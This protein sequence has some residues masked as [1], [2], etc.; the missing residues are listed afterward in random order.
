MTENSSVITGVNTQSYKSHVHV[1]TFEMGLFNASVRSVSSIVHAGPRKT[2]KGPLWCDGGTNSKDKNLKM[3]CGNCCC[4]LAHIKSDSTEMKTVAAPSF[5]RRTSQQAVV[6]LS[7]GVAVLAG[8]DAHGLFVRLPGL[9]AD[10]QQLAVDLTLRHSGAVA[11]VHLQLEELERTDVRPVSREDKKVF[12]PAGDS[13]FSISHIRTQTV[14]F[15][16]SSQAAEGVWI[17][18]Q[19]HLW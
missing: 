18:R 4:E 12:T 8:Q 1:Q 5:L 14:V 6:G 15:M 10:P 3:S 2:R 13:T 17:S 19:E 16:C 11:V 7:P 9:S